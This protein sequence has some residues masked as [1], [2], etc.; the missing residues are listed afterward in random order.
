MHT[1]IYIIHTYTFMYKMYI[2]I[3][4]HTH[5]SIL[6]SIAKKCILSNS[7]VQ[8]IFLHSK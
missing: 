4:I 5:I 7:F 1:Y 8:V 6:F 2:H 3:I